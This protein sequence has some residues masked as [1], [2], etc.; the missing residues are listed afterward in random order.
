ML[1]YSTFILYLVLKFLDLSFSWSS[2]S[3]FTSVVVV[4]PGELKKLPLLGQAR[5][6]KQKTS[7]K[8]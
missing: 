5:N 3:T 2:H 1:E 8:N 6:A 7:F 4:L